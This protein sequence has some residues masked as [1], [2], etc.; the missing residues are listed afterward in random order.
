MHAEGEDSLLLERLDLFRGA[1]VA[2]YDATG[3]DPVVIGGLAKALYALL[4][5][6]TAGHRTDRDIR[7]EAFV[8][9]Q[10]EAGLCALYEEQL[11]A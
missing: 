7:E 2:V 6:L 10:I 1:K 3:F 9:G 11:A 5:V 4:H 8:K